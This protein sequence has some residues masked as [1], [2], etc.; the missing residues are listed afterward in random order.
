MVQ[1]KQHGMDLLL[2]GGHHIN[3]G[4]GIDHYHML[5]A[6]HGRHLVIKAKIVNRGQPGAIAVGGNVIRWREG[7]RNAM[8]F[9]GGALR[10]GIFQPEHF[11]HVAMG[12]GDP[13]EGEQMLRA[14]GSG[15]V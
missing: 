5:P 9:Q 6:G 10:Y 4:D 8:V 13:A 2:A 1:T 15:R 3:E 11:L 7:H 12:I 14:T